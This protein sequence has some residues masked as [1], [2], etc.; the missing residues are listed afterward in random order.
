MKAYS[1]TC[2]VL[3]VAVFLLLARLHWLLG[4]AWGGLCYAKGYEVITWGAHKL[5]LRA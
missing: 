5:G 3:A 1:L 2:F 4:A